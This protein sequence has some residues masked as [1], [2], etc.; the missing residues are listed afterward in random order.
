MPKKVPDSIPKSVH[1][2]VKAK[3]GA[4]QER[5]EAHPDGSLE[6]WVREPPEEGRANEAIR[7]KVAEHFS[8]PK[9]DVELVRGA[10]SRVKLF[11]V[12]RLP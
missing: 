4:R 12:K 7:A 1:V 10:T 2:S 11:R 3:P 8:V 5:V 6:I 9:R